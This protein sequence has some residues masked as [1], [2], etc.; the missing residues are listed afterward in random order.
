[1]V[2]LG[3]KGKEPDTTCIPIRD[4]KDTAK[5][6]ELIETAQGPVSFMRSQA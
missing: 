3:H 1:M 6:T 5:F 2:Q 4:M